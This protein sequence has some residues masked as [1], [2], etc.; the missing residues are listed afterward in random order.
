MVAADLNDVES[1][2]AAFKGA[3]VAFG[4]TDFWQSVKVPANHAL[5]AKEGRTVNEV[6]YDI[7]VQQG[8][9]IVD[10][11]AA[12]VNTLDRFVL[13][14][15]SHTAKWSKGTITFNLH[16]DAKWMA[17]DYLRA[18]YPELAKKTSFL[19]V[20]LFATN[21]KSG[22]TMAPQKKGDGTYFLRIPMNGDA[23]IPMVDPRADTGHFTK[24]LVDV[25]PGKVLVG[26][27]TKL[28][29]KQWAHI[30][31]EHTGK[32]LTYEEADRSEMENAMPGGVG[33]ELADMFE[34][35]SKFGYDGSDPEVVYPADLG[36]EIPV[37]T[38]E[39]YIKKTDWSSVL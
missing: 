17:V 39:E 37:T 22:P 11:A 28:S 19:Q 30:W 1:L 5:A 6:A 32:T 33:K 18:T 25:E 10:A 9:N 2:K 3:N 16:F 27:A 34:Y 21:W 15:L 23:P 26:A 29:W 13:S 38:I 35:I 7:E 4:V 14:T 31:A 12:T 24:A 8:K 36:V 20:G